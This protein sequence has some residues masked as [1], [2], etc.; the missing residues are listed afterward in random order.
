M[1][2]LV[3]PFLGCAVLVFVLLFLYHC[4][5]RY[6]FGVSCP[7]CGMTRALCAAV[8]SDFE[9]AFSYHPL[10]PLLI[11]AALY[12]GLRRFGLMA[13]SAKRDNTYILLFT[14]LFIL[15]YILRL[16]ENDPVIAPDFEASLLF[17]VINFIK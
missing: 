10:F 4:P 1:R 8:F 5:F 2:R 6:I 3:K 7:G 11:P 9:T 12:I 17:R 16:I 14:A 15:V 13:P